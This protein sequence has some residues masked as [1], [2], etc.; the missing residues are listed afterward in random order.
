MAMDM[1]R[2]SESEK[3]RIIEDVITDP[4]YPHSP[5]P[6]TK[7]NK[8][9]LFEILA[10]KDSIRSSSL[11][12]RSERLRIVDELL[13]GSSSPFPP[14]VARS[15]PEAVKLEMFDQAVEGGAIKI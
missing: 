10:K 14:E 5:T 7:E 12:P 2:L 3:L 15:L 13:K 1:S 4:R 9:E 11:I 8:L 6:L